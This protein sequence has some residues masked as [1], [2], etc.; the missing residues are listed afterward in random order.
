M[1]TLPDLGPQISARAEHAARDSLLGPVVAAAKIDLSK[2]KWLK[3]CMQT[4]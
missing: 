2:S 4:L 1:I 3:K